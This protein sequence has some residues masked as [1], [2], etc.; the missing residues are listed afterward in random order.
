MAS[1][2]RD[3]SQAAPIAECH[4]ERLGG[5]HVLVHV[6][7]LAE[8]PEAVAE[9]DAEVQVPLE[10]LRCLGQPLEDAQRLFEPLHRVAVGGARG[11]LDAGATQVVHGFL[12]ELSGERMMGEHVHLLGETLRIEPLDGGGDLGVKRAPPR[13][14]QA[15]V[16]H[17]LGEC[18]LEHIFHARK[19]PGLV[20]ELRRLQAAERL[21]QDVLVDLRDFP[22]QRVRDV[23]A[24]DGRRLQQSLVRLG[25][26]VDTCDEHRAHRGG[27]LDGGERLRQTIAVTLAHERS[28]LDQDPHALFEKERIALRSLDEQRLHG[29]E[30]GIAPQQHVE[31]LFGVVLWQRLDADLGVL[32]L[33]APG[34]GVLGPIV[35]QQQDA[36]VRDRVDER[37]EHRLRFRVDPMKVFDHEHDGLHLRLAQ[38]EALDGVER[39]L[40]ALTR[41]QRFPGG[42][43]DGDVQQ[44]EDRC[45]ARLERPIQAHHFA[46]DFLADLGDIVA[47]LDLEVVPQ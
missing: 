1:R 46:D 6:H 9:T 45:Q 36:R 20:D 31:Q 18:V 35:H 43:V 19:E 30:L 7:E 3:L 27:N 11:R 15:L 26:P 28:G 16:G 13:L 34:V 38:K 24:D 42:V 4:G 5:A 33:R 17:V 37:V 39:P 21:L 40:P 2:G 25:Q 10:A 32:A 47:G 14:Q 22:Q 12:P 29:R 41:I 23:S 8:C 44:R